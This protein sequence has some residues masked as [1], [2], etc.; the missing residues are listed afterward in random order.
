MTRKRYSRKHPHPFAPANRKIS[1]AAQQV[2][3]RIAQGG[4]EYM[5]NNLIRV[6]R[7]SF[8]L[9][10][11]PEFPDLFFP[12]EQT[13]QVTDRWNNTKNV[14]MP[15]KRKALTLYTKYPYPFKKPGEISEVC[16][17]QE[18]ALDS[19]FGNFPKY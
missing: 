15:P 19:N 7:D 13:V 3:N 10:G 17:E 8:T 1:T 11:E 9:A 5:Q 4:V 6:M 12:S 18:N 14:W 2:A 16:V